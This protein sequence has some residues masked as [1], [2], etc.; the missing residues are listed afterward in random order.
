MFARRWFCNE[1]FTSNEVVESMNSSLLYGSKMQWNAVTIFTFRH[2]YIKF[3]WAV[4]S[5]FM[6]QPNKPFHHFEWRVW[7]ICF[8]LVDNLPSIDTW[9]HVINRNLFS[10]SGDLHPLTDDR[11][12][13]IAS[14]RRT[15]CIITI[16]TINE[17]N[18]HELE[19]FD[20]SMQLFVLVFIL[21]TGRQ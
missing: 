13:L 14:V 10:L 18:R 5:P 21:S 7:N 17:N 4:R 12:Q 8:V 2:L 9:T 11:S 6:W 15:P 1:T 20:A 3:S 19:R 16:I